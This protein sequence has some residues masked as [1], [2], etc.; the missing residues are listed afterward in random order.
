[1]K[2]MIG[3]TGQKRGVE[4]KYGSDLTHL[5]TK[6]IC[7]EPRSS[8]VM[9][10]CKAMTISFVISRHLIRQY[11]LLKRFRSCGRTA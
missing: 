6:E 10:Y 9:A 1:M 3:N 5:D 2:G 4:L 8:N 11:S 7:L